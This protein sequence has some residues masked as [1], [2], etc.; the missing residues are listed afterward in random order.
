MS[1]SAKPQ[2]PKLKSSEKA[3]LTVNLNN[4][5][6]S[7]KAYYA[8]KDIDITKLKGG[9]IAFAAL[10]ESFTRLI[11]NQCMKTVGKSKSN[12][13]ELRRE[14]MNCSL[15]LNKDFKSYYVASLEDYK[16]NGVYSNVI[17][18]TQKEMDEI[19]GEFKDV[20]LSPDA[21]NY[22]HFLLSK[23]YVDVASTCASLCTYAK[24]KSLDGLCVVSAL[25]I[26]FE[27]QLYEPLTASVN[28]AMK[29]SGRD[30]EAK[31]GDEDE[32]E[33][34][35]EGGEFED[36]NADGGAEE[37]AAEST[38]KKKPLS[39]AAQTAKGPTKSTTVAAPK[40]VKGKPAVETKVVTEPKNTSKNGKP[41]PQIQVSDDDDDAQADD[42]VE[43]QEAEKP[44]TK[45]NSKKV[46]VGNKSTN[47]K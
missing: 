27:K 1:K 38:D 9:H 43:T 26:L 24:K 7:L 5:S 40:T 33:E 44:S 21:K 41:K 39:K 23:V 11:V 14:N 16:E 22:M 2:Q 15:L 36:D 17:P 4:V 10:L 6:K 29:L 13:L 12:L 3:N 46:S 37:E 42:D 47:K 25:R 20:S 30:L 34:T 28:L 45:K 19:L 18:M 8:S 32:A 35:H 31:E